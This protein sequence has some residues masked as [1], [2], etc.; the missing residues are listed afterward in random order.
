MAMR[1]VL[2]FLILVAG[3]G[4]PAERSAGPQP[5]APGAGVAAAAAGAPEAP[6]LADALQGETATREVAGLTFANREPVAAPD[7]SL[8]D[9]W[10]DRVQLSDYRGKIVALHFWAKWCGSCKGDLQYFQR[11]H[12][13]YGGED[14]VVLGL[15]VDSGSRK[16]IG[17][18]AREVGVTFP[19]LACRDEVK[20]AYD[21]ATFPTNI[22]IDREGNIAH[23]VQR[24]MDEIFWDKMFA[25][26]IG[27]R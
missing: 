22:I 7:F 12:E 8:T 19:M 17:E 26:M 2:P 16:A 4:G 23:V 25:E 1:R 24:R 6:S 20:F 14:F 15:G 21:V 10:G 18:F 9:T 11:V 27:S 13:R 5:S 3:C